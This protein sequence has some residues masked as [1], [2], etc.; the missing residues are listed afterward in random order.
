MAPIK[1]P[2]FFLQS[3]SAYFLGNHFQTKLSTDPVFT[4][5]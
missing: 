2:W 3:L 4:L 5:H 1:F